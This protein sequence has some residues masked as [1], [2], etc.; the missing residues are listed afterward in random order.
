MK[1]RVAYITIIIILL[2]SMSSVFA[3]ESYSA[4]ADQS[5]ELVSEVPTAVTIKGVGAKKLAVEFNCA[6]AYTRT[7]DI[8]VTRDGST[9]TIVGTTWSEDKK[10]A[11]LTTSYN[12]ISSEK[13]VVTAT[14]GVSE[15]I[16]SAETKID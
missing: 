1:R 7:M 4:L 14:Y 9:V 2:C 16:K 12:L 3:G 11:I 5:G 15:A 6:V 10:T 13:Y 8:R